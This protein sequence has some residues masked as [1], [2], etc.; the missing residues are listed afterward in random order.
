MYVRK[1]YFYVSCTWYKSLMRSKFIF[2]C[3]H[4][5]WLV[6]MEMC[7]SL[8]LV[9][10]V[11]LFEIDCAIFYWNFHKLF[12]QFI[13]W[14]N[15]GNSGKSMDNCWMSRRVM[16]DMKKSLRRSH[17]YQTVLQ[18]PLRLL[19]NKLYFSITWPICLDSWSGLLFRK[20]LRKH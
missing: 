2:L 14:T 4:S 12:C 19:I 9:I 13:K 6:T 20:N 1:K 3:C 15:F 5:F 8:L 18:S 7:Y 17:N 16:A 11:I 10:Q